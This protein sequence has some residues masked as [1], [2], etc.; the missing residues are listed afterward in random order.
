MLVRTSG[1]NIA[2]TS[3]FPL[4]LSLSL[5]SEV[6]TRARHET[7]GILSRRGRLLVLFARN[8]RRKQRSRVES[9]DE[10]VGTFVSRKIFII[11]EIRRERRR[12]VNYSNKEFLKLV[13]SCSDSATQRKE[14]RVN[15]RDPQSLHPSLRFYLWTF[16]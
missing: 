13:I 3:L 1:H 5:T 8:E 4:S 10:R 7:S 9:R 16:E 14:K 2:S 12:E 15:Y 6:V 11:R